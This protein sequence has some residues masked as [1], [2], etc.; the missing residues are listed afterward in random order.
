MTSLDD[1][2]AN[3]PFIP[4]AETYPPKWSQEAQD[5]RNSLGTQAD[6]G[7]SY[8]PSDRQCF[9]MFHPDGDAQGTLIFVHGGYWRAFDNQSWSH[10]AKGALGRNWA[11]AMPSYDLCPDVS[12]AAITQQ[13]AIAIT[14]IA[15]QTKG[16]IALAGHSAGGHLVARMMAEGMLHTRVFNR[17]SHVAPI[18]PLC[19]LEPL[20]KTAMNDDFR[21]DLA[22]AR[23]ESPLLQSPPTV[24]VTIWVGAAER[25]AFVDQARWLASHWGCSIVEDT[26]KNHF[27]IIDALEDPNSEI[28][29]WLTLIR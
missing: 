12:I 24:P 29:E 2:Y 21:M 5:F 15:D 25:P 1:E 16:P 8:G 7:L 10:L 6:L 3:G 20:T 11:V 14:R 13:I 4:N 9:D 17:I 23:A 22:M 18:S 27:D 28:V 26:G 19:D